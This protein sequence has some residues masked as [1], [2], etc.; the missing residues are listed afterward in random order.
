M[1]VDLPFTGVSSGFQTDLVTSVF[2]CGDETAESAGDKSL[3]TFK[4]KVVS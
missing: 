3:Q 2:V 1:L 4:I